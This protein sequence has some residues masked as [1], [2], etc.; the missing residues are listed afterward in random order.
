K[1]R[2]SFQLQMYHTFLNIA[3]KAEKI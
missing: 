2:K 3:R 1:R